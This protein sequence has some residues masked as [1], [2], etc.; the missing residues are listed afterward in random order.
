VRHGHVAVNGRKLDVPSAQLKTGD[1]VGFSPRGQRSEYFAILKETM[2]SKEIPA[3]VTVD[4][5]AMTGR[6][7]SL[8][9]L[10]EIDH[11]F[12]ENVIIEYYSR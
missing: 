9:S 5:E 10:G 2:Q 6:L 7:L 4:R 3:W 12:N 11:K 1:E 8:P